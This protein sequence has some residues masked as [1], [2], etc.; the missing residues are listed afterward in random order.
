MAELETWKNASNAFVAVTKL[1]PRGQEKTEII[2]S[3]KTFSLTSEERRINQDRCIEVANDFFKNGMLMPI[4]LLD[5]DEEVAELASSAN[6]MSD[7]ELQDLFGQHWRT[8]E[9][10]INEISSTVTLQRMLDL[11]E[12][13]DATHKQV[14]TIQ[15]RMFALDPTS[16]PKEGVPLIKIKAKPGIQPRGLDGDDPD[17]ILRH[18]GTLED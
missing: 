15:S 5:G 18:G 8:F 9:K 12:K 3:G 13:V 2:E 6:L 4:R 11:S 16:F 10:R 17:Y 14:T 1:D 7:S